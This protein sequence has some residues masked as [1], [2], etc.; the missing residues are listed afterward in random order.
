MLLFLL[1]LTLFFLLSPLWIELDSG[2][3]SGKIR[4]WGIGRVELYHEGEW[5]VRLRLLFFQKIYYLERRG[6]KKEKRVKK[7]IAATG[8][9]KKPV[10]PFRLMLKKMI[11]IIRSFTIEQWRLDMDTGDAALNARLYP[12]NWLPVLQGHVFVNFNGEQRFRCRIRNNGWRL[13]WAWFRK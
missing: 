10:M 5:K 13:L 11:R 6:A 9:K 3:P 1:C 12:L 4:W 8:V 7:K 2:I